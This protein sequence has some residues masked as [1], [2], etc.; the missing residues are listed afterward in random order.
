MY[1]FEIETIRR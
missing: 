1:T